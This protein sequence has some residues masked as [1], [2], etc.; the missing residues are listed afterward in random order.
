MP[1]W[2]PPLTG[3]NAA[4][5]LQQIPA[6]ALT[7]SVNIVFQGNQCSLS[8]LKGQEIN[9]SGHFVT[10]ELGIGWLF[11]FEINDLGFDSFLGRFQEFCDN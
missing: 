10:V 5:D 11:G 7:N 3:L 1:G 2:L 9:S 6:E 8:P 4:W